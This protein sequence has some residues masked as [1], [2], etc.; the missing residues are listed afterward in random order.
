MDDS[1]DVKDYSELEVITVAEDINRSLS[2]NIKYPCLFIEGITIKSE[3]EYFSKRSYATDISLPLY[4]T[5][6]GMTKCIG[7]FELSVD[8]LLSFI[9]IYTYR[10]F[11]CTDENKRI[12]IDLKSPESLVRFIKL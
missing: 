11:L 4:F 6:Q 8:S 12:E 10:L 3:I 7:Q 1:S 9:N 2:D 5:L